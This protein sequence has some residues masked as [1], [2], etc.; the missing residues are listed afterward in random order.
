MAFTYGF[1][2]SVSGDRKYNATQFS[3]F[4]DGIISDGVLPTVGQAFEVLASGVDVVVKP[5]RAWFNRTW[6]LNDSDLT[7]PLPSPS[8]VN[9]RIDSLVLEID[10]RIETRA[11]SIKWVNGAPSVSPV[12]PTLA[13]PANVYQYPLA[14]VYRDRD[15][16]TVM[17]G[18]ITGLVGTSM[19]PFA[20]NALVSLDAYDTLSHKRGIVRGN[21][22]G[23]VYTPEQQAAV[24]SG[25]FENLYLGDYWTHGGVNWRI[26][27][28]DY[29]LGTPD[30]LTYGTY[31]TKHHLVIIP[32]NTL[33]LVA[34]PRPFPS[35]RTYA[36]CGLAQSSTVMAQL[37]T[38][39]DASGPLFGVNRLLQRQIRLTNTYSAQYRAM[40]TMNTVNYRSVLPTESMLHGKD[41]YNLHWGGNDHNFLALYKHGVNYIYMG[42]DDGHPNAG[43]REPM[44]LHGQWYEQAWS[45]YDMD[46]GFWTLNNWYLPEAQ[47]QIVR[48]IFGVTGA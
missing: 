33:P 13:P 9:P 16:M 12:P 30:K 14:N 34:K 7:L 48:P 45:S 42:N 32:D 27:D 26:V 36:N 39:P 2:N 24:N 17:Q 19:C 40:N 1:Y 37:N 5:G 15:G 29:W 6:S 44:W 11:N 22:L 25:T 46:Y 3:H 41:S 18:D 21:H 47:R 28:F 10:T 20:S 31:V 8:T 4:F 38:I 35:A 43:N 23:S